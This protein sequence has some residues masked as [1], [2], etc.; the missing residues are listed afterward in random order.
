MQYGNPAENILIE[1]K[2]AWR[3]LSSIIFSSSK[4]S[5]LRHLAVSLPF[6][7]QLDFENFLSTSRKVEAI[8]HIQRHGQYHSELWSLVVLPNGEAAADPPESL[9]FI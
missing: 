8:S 4:H 1:P 6:N 3:H 9:R 5:N 7:K 2:T